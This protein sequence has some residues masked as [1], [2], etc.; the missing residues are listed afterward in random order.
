MVT[1]YETY[2]TWID[3]GGS[4]ADETDE[5]TAA[6]LTEYFFDYRLGWTDPDRF[7]RYYKR[8]LGIYYPMY[9]E[10]LRVQPGGD[11][12]LSLD[13][14]VQSYRER[15]LKHTG[16]NSG[17]SN[18]T[19]TVDDTKTSNMQHTTELDT[20]TTNM[21]DTDAAAI[22][23]DTKSGGHTDNVNGSHTDVITGGHTE[24]HV[25]GTHTTEVSPH[26]SKVRTN[27]GHVSNWNGHS[28]VAA[29]LPMSNS[30]ST[31][32]GEGD[33]ELPGIEESGG[34]YK[35]AYQ[36]MPALK[37]QSP[38]SQGQSGDR[39]YTVDKSTVTESYQYDDEKNGDKTV[40]NGSK[41]DPDTTETTYNAET[42]TVTYNGEGHTFTYNGEMDTKNIGARTHTKNG[43]VTHNN[44]SKDIG[45]DTDNGTIKDAGTTTGE[46]ESTDREIYTGRDTTPAE[47]IKEAVKVIQH[48]NAFSWFVDQLKPCFLADMEDY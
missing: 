17:T 30:Y 28:E 46:D 21:T 15:Q 25:E 13:W 42:H 26:V 47:I 36:H 8:N 9:Q 45:T 22:D 20:T 11:K 38:S 33:E 2:Q 29:V 41:T 35:H 48:T 5:A 4:V 34:G 37:W 27:G 16:K 40:S 31:F 14:F 39:G 32:I 6:A 43:E 3:N 24:N 23:T 7:S 10:Q 44:I 19:H 18:N 12:L 1:D